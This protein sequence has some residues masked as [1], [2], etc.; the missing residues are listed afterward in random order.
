MIV[1]YLIVLSCLYTQ[2][3]E[4]KVSKSTHVWIRNR[5]QQTHFLSLI[6]IGDGLL[7]YH[8][9]SSKPQ[10]IICL[11]WYSHEKEQ[12]YSLCVCLTGIG[13]YCIEIKINYIII[14]DKSSW[15][16]GVGYS[17]VITTSRNRIQFT[18]YARRTWLRNTLQSLR[19]NCQNTMGI[20]NWDTYR[21][22]LVKSFAVD[23]LVRSTTLLPCFRSKFSLFFC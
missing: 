10:S 13:L 7:S 15:S 8:T 20:Q 1:L 18:F 16:F 19:L 12:I 21:R 22:I 17:K 2:R 6:S 14:A 4:N 5:V 9:K 11:L 3:G 23:M